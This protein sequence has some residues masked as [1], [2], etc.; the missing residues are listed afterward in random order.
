MGNT[1]EASSGGLETRV[2]LSGYRKEGENWDAHS[3]I[4][5]AFLIQQQEH[6]SVSEC[7]TEITG[8]VRKRSSLILSP[9]RVN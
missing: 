8:G 3:L 6:S 5:P 7:E 4:Q 1:L 9:C 2:P